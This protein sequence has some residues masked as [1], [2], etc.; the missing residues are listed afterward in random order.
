MK[1]K[2]GFLLIGLLKLQ[3]NNGF[4]SS[5]CILLVIDQIFFSE[6]YI[7]LYH[8]FTKQK[9]N[10]FMKILIF[11]NASTYL[12]MSCWAMLNFSGKVF[13]E[14]RLQRLQLQRLHDLLH[15]R[16]RHFLFSSSQQCNRLE[17][18]STIGSSRTKNK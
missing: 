2:H 6:S 16:Q 3:F 11:T 4:T 15:P 9:R 10:F 14:S 12:N 7:Y 13:T 1:S 17:P 8:I 18:L 5:N